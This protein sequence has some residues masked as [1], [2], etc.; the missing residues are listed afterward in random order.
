LEAASLARPL[1]VREIPEYSPWLKH[2]EH[3]LKAQS[4]VQFITYLRE[5][6]EDPRWYQQLAQGAAD[7]AQAYSVA[8]I[9]Q[10]LRKLYEQILAGQPID[11]DESPAVHGGSRTR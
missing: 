10:R 7:L 11:E 3:C 9:G 6:A 8:Q 2:G 1:V 4:N 5:L